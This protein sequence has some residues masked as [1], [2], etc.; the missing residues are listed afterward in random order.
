VRYLIQVPED[1][2]DE[3]GWA[4]G[5]QL[6]AV[7]AGEVLVVFPKRA[8]RM[9]DP[10]RDGKSSAPNGGGRRG[11]RRVSRGSRDQVPVDGEDPGH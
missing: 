5:M 8:P 7:P 6:E 11:G 4:E 1:V 10:S 2:G 3:V 9:E